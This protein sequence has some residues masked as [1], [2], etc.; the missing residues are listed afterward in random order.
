MAR[1]YLVVI[2]YCYCVINIT[3]CYGVISNITYCYGVMS[4]I[5]SC[6]LLLYVQYSVIWP[7][8][9]LYRG[10]SSIHRLFVHRPIVSFIPTTGVFD[11]WPMIAMLLLPTIC[12]ATVPSRPRFPHV[13]S[14]FGS[15]SNTLPL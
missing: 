9:T 2:V 12:L 14:S 13:A 8:S 1:G 10:L 3:H 5:L 11:K 15:H 7:S 6:S 4:H